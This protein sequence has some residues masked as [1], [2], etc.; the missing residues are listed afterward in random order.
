MKKICSATE[1]DL[2]EPLHQLVDRLITSF[3]P[4]AL[5]N[6]IFFVNEIPVNLQVEHNNECVA[7][8][9]SGMITSVISDSK[10]NCIR[11]TAKK[12][13]HVLVL[14]LAE[15]GAAQH[16]LNADLQQMQHLAEKIGGCLFINTQ[17]P[18]KTLLSFSFPNLPV[19]V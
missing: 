17:S 13:G 11:F 1:T 10:E 9:I 12:F 3:S 14:E 5:R 16:H 2:M 19:A 6:H 15:N 7:S 8:V 18:N 4:A